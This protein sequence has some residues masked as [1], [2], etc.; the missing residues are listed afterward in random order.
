MFQ[1][2]RPL[3][4]FY[5][6]PLLISPTSSPPRAASAPVHQGL[7]DDLMRSNDI[8]AMFVEDTTTHP[9]ASTSTG[10][11]LWYEEGLEKLNALRV[12]ESEVEKTQT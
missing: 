11:D 2:P 12:A 5:N 8:D 1:I 10:T 7:I 6:Q 4:K 3:V 9:A